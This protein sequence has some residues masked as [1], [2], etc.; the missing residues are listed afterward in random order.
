MR[1]P[2]KNTGEIALLGRKE[3]KKMK[4]MQKALAVLLT[5]AL[6]FAVGAVCAFAADGYVEPASVTVTQMPNR[7]VYYDGGDNDGSTIYGD[8][9]GMV[10]TVTYT[11]GS[12]RE[13]EAGNENEEDLVFIYVENYVIG[14]NMATVTYCYTIG[15]EGIDTTIPVTVK[16][17]PVES[18]EITKMPIKTEYDMDK[19]VLTRENFTLERYREV[20]PEDFEAVLDAY[21]VTYEEFVAYYGEEFLKNMIFADRDA[22]LPIQSEGMEIRVTF[23]DGSSTV[24]NDE[25]DG[26]EY[27]G[28]VYPITLEQKSNTVT[29]GE[30]T[31]AV[32]FMDN[33]A[34]FN[35]NVK[36][37]AVN[38]DNGDNG[39]NG[40]NG[41]NSA[42]NNPAVKDDVKNPDIPKTGMTAGITAAAVL[43][44][45]GT[46][47][48][49]L[50]LRRKEDK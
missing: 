10:L 7:T 8:P 33:R 40:G 13:V 42:T 14:E 3:D 24:V 36:K 46:A 17:N 44:L 15:V 27:D 31:F 16:E 48:S 34:E 25:Y 32:V 19:D 4:R 9:T 26:I 22:F 49:V 39:N 12:T 35:V 5:A 50:L 43:M 18:I 45:S 11:D 37:A 23:K 21:G 1:E 6:L 2:E 41:G 30:N 20:A 47:G 28:Y 38:G 29:E